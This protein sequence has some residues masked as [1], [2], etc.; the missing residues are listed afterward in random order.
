MDEFCKRHNLIHPSSHKC[1][2]CA[3][4][5]DSTLDDD[6]TFVPQFKAEVLR[7]RG[8]RLR[9]EAHITGLR[10]LQGSSGR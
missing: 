8:V 9:P 6:T 5:S 10:R 3:V 1:S 2:L 7:R 4:E